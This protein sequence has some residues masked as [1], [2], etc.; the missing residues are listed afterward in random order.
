L[1]FAALFFLYVGTEATVSGWLTT[2]AERMHMAIARVAV[3]MPSFFWAALLAGRALAPTLLRRVEEARLGLAGLIVSGAGVTILLLAP[4]LAT[5]AA[6]SV[7]AGFGLAAIFPLLISAM[8]HRFG[9]SATRIT[10]AMFLMSALGGASLPLLAGFASTTFG[11]PRAAM[12]VALGSDI[13][14]LSL[15]FGAFAR[16]VSTGS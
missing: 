16:P 14:M 15:A 13:A 3:L 4:T 6:G 2:Y 9:S 5:A 1:R 11:S 10:S 8:T 12:V 7:A